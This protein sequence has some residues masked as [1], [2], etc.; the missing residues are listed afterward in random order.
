MTNLKKGDT[1]PPFF[2]KNQANEDISL[3]DFKGKKIILYFYPRNNTPTCTVQACNLRDN[4]ETLQKEGF[5]VLG[6][7]PD[8]VQSHAKFAAKHTLPFTLIADPD[9][10]IAKAYGVYGEKKFMGRISMGIF[11]TTFEINEQGIIS[12]VITKVKAK[13][14]SQQLLI[15][16]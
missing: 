9:K 1:A 2:A 14:H 5:T 16:Q 11:R 15:N 8:T 4:H 10:I 7:S 12:N 13:I 6:I 3:E